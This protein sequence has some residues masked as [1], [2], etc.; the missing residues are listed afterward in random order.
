MIVLDNQGV[1]FASL[2]RK[3]YKDVYTIS[4]GDVL[5]TTPFKLEP[6]AIRMYMAAWNF[7]SNLKKFLQVYNEWMSDNSLD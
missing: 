5:Y 6:M 2:Y 4:K 7:R 3:N 1:S